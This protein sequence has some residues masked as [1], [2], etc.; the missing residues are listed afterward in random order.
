ME[1]QDREICFLLVQVLSIAPKALKKQRYKGFTQHSILILYRC[2][3]PVDI[4][5]LCQFKDQGKNG[6]M[7]SKVPPYLS[8]VILAHYEP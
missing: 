8:S 4:D 7:T 1:A 6:L 5:I 2:L 3:L